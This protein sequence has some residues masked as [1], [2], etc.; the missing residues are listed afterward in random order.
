M[1]DKSIT[2]SLMDPPSTRL[3]TVELE[4]GCMKRTVSFEA[5]SKL[6]QL[7]I[8]PSEAWI[9]NSVSLRFSN[10]TSPFSI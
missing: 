3:R 8:A 4:S 9:F 10:W 7:M 5:I 1:A 2:I 6:C